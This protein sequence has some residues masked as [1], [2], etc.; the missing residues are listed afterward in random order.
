MSDIIRK[1]T[2][3]SPDF[4]LSYEVG[5]SF[6]RGKPSELKVTFICLD[7][8]YLTKFGIDKYDI[9]AADATGSE[10]KQ[11]KIWKSFIRQKTMIEFNLFSK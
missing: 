6:N 1:L 4:G 11:A 9:Y 10:D 5:Q 8:E 2:I 7:A 3:G